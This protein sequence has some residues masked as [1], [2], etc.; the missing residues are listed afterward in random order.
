M[1]R[2]YAKGTLREERI[3]NETLIESAQ[4]QKETFQPQKAGHLTTVV[5][6]SETIP[7]NDRWGVTALCF[8][9]TQ[10][11][12]WGTE[13]AKT[14]PAQCRTSPAAHGS[15][16]RSTWQLGPSSRKP[17]HRPSSTRWVRGWRTQL[18]PR[19]ETHTVM[20]CISCIIT[21][22][23]TKQGRYQKQWWQQR[24]MSTKILCALWCLTLLTRLWGRYYFHPCFT[25]GKLGQRAINH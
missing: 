21:V 10:E 25:Y 9:P 15:A 13:I 19:R 16:S 8:P 14:R 22:P 11:R 2:T 3:Q 20:S 24:Q 23:V 6:D 4:K 1:S 17:N 12:P 18:G 7:D 5:Q